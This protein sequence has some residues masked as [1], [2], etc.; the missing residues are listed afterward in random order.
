MHATLP[1]TEHERQKAHI[2]R[3]L[4]SC[5]ISV[6]D[7]SA[8]LGLCERQIYR[9]KAAFL[10]EGDAALVHHLRGTSSNHRYANAIRE[11]V[12]DLYRRLYVDFGPTLFHETLREH[13]QLT[14]HHETLR[15]WLRDAGLWQRARAGR[16]H[17][18]K[19][20]RRSAIGELVQ[21]DGSVHDWFEGR[22]SPCCLFVFI[23]DASNQS[24]F[25][26][27]S[28]ENEHAALTVLMH[29]IRLFGIPAAVY[30]D[31]HSVYWSETGLTQFARALAALNCNVIYARSPQAKGR[32]ERA[33]RTHQD[34]LVKALRLAN[35]SSIE[36]ANAFLDAGYRAQHNARFAHLDDLPDVH[37]DPGRTDLD[38]IICHQEERRVNHDMTIQ[39]RAQWY[40]ILPGND[41]C[42][43]PKQRVIIR[44]WLDGSLHVFW[45]EHELNVVRCAQRPVR[46]A[47]PVHP[48][49][50]H[51]WRHMPP[52]GKAKRKTIAELCRNTK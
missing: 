16:R 48:P 15:R 18:R 12:L 10:L 45:R 5:Q 21:V 4:C 22:G 9:L 33:N 26:F 52:I 51:P 39:V 28:S 42:P 14:I 49:D 30:V 13:H 46:A 34:R 3:L 37:R 20:Q 7:A 43:L 19:R 36:E 27:A 23:D 40:Q 17:R 38:N 32:V 24:Y 11:E 47:P 1:M 25:R 31:R 29:Y 6:A 2:M 41:L 50:D 8:Q 35:I 44:F